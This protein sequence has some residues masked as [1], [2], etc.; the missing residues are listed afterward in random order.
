MLCSRLSLTKHPLILFFSNLPLCS[1]DFLLCCTQT[2]SQAFYKY[3][4]KLL[5]LID[6][7]FPEDTNIL[8]ILFFLHPKYL[9]LQN[10][11]LAKHYASTFV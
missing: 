9:T 1:Q 11:W 5:A 7:L 8:E 3:I 10:I 6:M 4:P 2:W